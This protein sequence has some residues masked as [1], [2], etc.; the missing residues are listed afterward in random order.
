VDDRVRLGLEHGSAHGR[1]IEQIERDVLR[2]ERPYVFGLL[3]R[4]RGADHL[5]A[6]VD[7]LGDQPRAD[8]TARSYKKDSHR[9]SPFRH[10]ARVAGVYCY[11]PSRPPDVT[12]G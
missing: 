12:D 11:D 10:I 8:R 1:A 5:M 3:G 2:A 6:S 7:K 4:P 9:V